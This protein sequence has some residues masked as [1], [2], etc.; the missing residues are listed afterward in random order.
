MEVSTRGLRSIINA[1]R[2]AEKSFAKPFAGEKGQEAARILRF[3]PRGIAE[4]FEDSTEYR[5]A[6]AHP[7][8]PTEAFGDQPAPFK[9]MWRTGAY[10]AA[11]LGGAGGFTDPTPNSVTIGVKSEVFPQVRIHQSNRSSTKIFA[12][13]PA[14]MK[15]G[16]EDWAMRFKLH[17]ISGIWFSKDKVRVVG[18]KIERRRLS[19]SSDVKKAIARSINAEFGRSAAKFKVNVVGFS[20]DRTRGYRAVA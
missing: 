1:T 2:D 13:T 9:T 19:V 20:I 16:G 8:K 12:K 5:L 10:R 6:T 4:Q 11:W 15:N 7:W 18:F 3:G 17:Q 14:R